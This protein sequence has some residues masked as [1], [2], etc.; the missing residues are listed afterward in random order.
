MNIESTKNLSLYYFVILAAIVILSALFLFVDLALPLGVVAG[1]LY[2][3]VVLFG[4]WLPHW[5][6]TIYLAVLVT[7]LMILGYYLSDTGSVSWIVV[8]NRVLTLVIIWA[9]AAFIV[10]K[11]RV[12]KKLKLSA[13]VLINGHYDLLTKLPNRVLL[14]ILLSK[15]ME[16][17]N[18]N[19]KSLA[20]VFID[21]DK[22]KHIND[23]YGH[24]YR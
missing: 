24:L 10:L 1:A 15:A 6:Y 8:T 20:L 5:L 11:K 2:I 22:F 21:L 17:C 18:R 3:I 7:F 19:K 23:T 13:D 4:F 14:S 9:T 16:H 12:D